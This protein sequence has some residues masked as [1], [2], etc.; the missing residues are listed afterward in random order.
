MGAGPAG[1]EMARV[2]ALRGHRVRVVERG[3]RVGGMAAVAGPGAALVAWWRGELERLGVTVELGVS[4]QIGD[5]PSELEPRR[6]V[7]V[8]CTGS[9]RGDPTYEIVDDATVLDVADVRVDPSVL[10]DAG[11]VVLLD[12][13]GGPIAVALA[14]ELGERAVL[15]TPDNVAGNELSRSGDLA[16]ANVRLLQRSVRIERRTIVREVR[17]DPAGE[18]GLAVEVEDRFSGVRRTIPCAAVV[19]CGFRLPDPPLAVA[20]TAGRG[21]CRPPH[22]P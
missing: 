20:A 22:D 6:G 21:L 8:Q 1:L 12:A 15:V 4:V 5:D 14:E 10:P 3:D 11:V 17:R 16:P 13:V 18:G 7:V 9:R 2:A 19:D